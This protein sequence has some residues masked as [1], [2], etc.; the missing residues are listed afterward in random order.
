MVKG[1]APPVLVGLFFWPRPLSALG[2]EGSD[3]HK[4]N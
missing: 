4:A 1:D 3:P 2:K